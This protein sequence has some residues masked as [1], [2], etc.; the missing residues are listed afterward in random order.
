MYKVPKISDGII[1]SFLIHASH[2]CYDPTTDMIFLLEKYRQ[3]H[4]IS[5][6]NRLFMLAQFFENFLFAAGT[7]RYFLV[8]VLDERL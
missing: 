7:N 5:N 6:Y 8:G 1:L 4:N 3:H 2:K